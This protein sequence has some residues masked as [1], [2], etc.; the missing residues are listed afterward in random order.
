MAARAAQGEPHVHR[1][2]CGAGSAL[3]V[4]PEDRTP[5]PARF[6]ADTGKMSVG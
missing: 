6:P 3:A 5:A 1:L 4:L 2:P